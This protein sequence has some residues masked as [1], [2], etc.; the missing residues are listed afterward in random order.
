[1]TSNRSLRALLG[2]ASVALSLGA[3]ASQPKAQDANSIKQA[4]QADEQEW[5]AEFHA[6]PRDME[7]LVAHYAD[8]AYFTAP[9]AP[10]ASGATEIRK[11][12]ATGLTDPNFDI[13]FAADKIDVAA[14]GDL[15][16]ARGRFTE[17]FT[18]P[19]TSQPVSVEG[20]FVTV[21]RKQADG[22]WKAVEDFAVADPGAPKPVAPPKPATRAKMTSL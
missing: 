2:A 17:K 21:Y 14:S 3:C 6:R 8:D 10:P 4:I 12:Y 11:S 13:S 18:D 16:Y 7:A 15:A 20:S 22:S 5:N 19:K 1:M 9:G